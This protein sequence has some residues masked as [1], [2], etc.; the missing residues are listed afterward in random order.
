MYIYIDAACIDQ[1]KEAVNHDTIFYNDQTR[2]YP[3]C[4]FTIILTCGELLLYSESILDFMLRGAELDSIHHL[5][6]QLPEEKKYWR[7][8]LKRIVQLYWL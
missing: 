5:N 7:D 6:V 4:I 3:P 2:Y 1:E 8:I